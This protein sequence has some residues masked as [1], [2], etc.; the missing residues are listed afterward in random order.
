MIA[1]ERKV[2]EVFERYPSAQA[3]FARFGFRAL[4]NPLLRKTFGQLTTIERG[5]KLHRVPL[6]SFL[7]A[8]N[9]AAFQ[10]SPPSE[11]PGPAIAADRPQP[12]ASQPQEIMELLDANVGALIQMHP[13]VKTVFIRYFG[14]GCFECPAFG[15]ETVGFACLMHHANPGAFARDC[16][17]LMEDSEATGDNP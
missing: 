15:T 10:T 3:V 12:N 16:L 4:F 7:D 1:K 14:P 2:A 6:E 8:L 9:Q 13:R 11:S 5:C 17:A